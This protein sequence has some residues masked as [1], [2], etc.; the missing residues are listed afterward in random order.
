MN[1]ILFIDDEVRILDA[2]RR[3]VRSKRDDWECCF[4]AS[5]DEGWQLIQEWSPDAIVSDLNMPGKSGIDLL[6]LVRAEEATRFLP[7]LMLTGNSEMNQRLACLEAGATD[8][9]N[10][11]C[12]FVELFTRLNNAI[13]LKSFQDQVRQ[14]NE[15]LERKVRERTRELEASRREVIFRLAIAAEMRDFNTGCHILRVALLSKMLAEDLGCDEDFCESIFLAS[16]MH[17]VGKIGVADSILR[18]PG[19]LTDTERAEMQEH[20]DLGAKLLKSKLNEVFSHLEEVEEVQTRNNLLEL[21]AN[22][23]LTH[24]EWVDGSGYPKGLKGDEIPLEGMIVAVADVYDAL[25][26]KRPYKDSYPPVVALQMIKEDSGTHFKSD[27]VESLIR[28]HADAEDIIA[29]HTDL[30]EP[31]SKNQA[32]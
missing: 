30:E 6:K 14:Q 16:T 20:C 32:A 7:F 19:K 3:M 22:I 24:H 13:A 18:K 17:D 9:L 11:P 28:R 10:K 25:R 31:K 4:A 29:R 12:D 8:F 27:V 15:I 1:K 23:A 2:F 26:A 21:S 5:V